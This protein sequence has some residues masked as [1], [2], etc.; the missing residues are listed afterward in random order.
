M[1]NVLKSMYGR[2]KVVSLE[3]TLNMVTS[4]TFFITEAN[5]W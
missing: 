5:N 2:K 1:Y 4:L 3:Q